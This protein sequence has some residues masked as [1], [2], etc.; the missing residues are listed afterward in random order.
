MSVSPVTPHDWTQR[1]HRQKHPQGLA[2]WGPGD[3]RPY[4]TPTTTR[5]GGRTAG[6]GGVRGSDGSASPTNS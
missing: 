5:V 3:R 2:Q 6:L 4:E 1:E